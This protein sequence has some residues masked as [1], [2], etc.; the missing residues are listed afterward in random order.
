[1]SRAI[2]LAKRPCACC[3]EMYS[4]KR[5]GQA[6]CSIACGRKLAAKSKRKATRAKKRA[7]M[8]L[9]DARGVLGQSDA[10]VVLDP[11]EVLG[12]R[13]SQAHEVDPYVTPVAVDKS[14]GVVARS[15][16]KAKPLSDVERRALVLATPG[17]AEE[18]PLTGRAAAIRN[19]VAL[20]LGYIF[21][22]EPVTAG[23]GDPA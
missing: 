10:D 2:Y 13:G 21:E 6:A 12:L 3:G 20:E 18:M 4:P 9:R 16:T 11:R 22:S 5:Q 19:A 23:D 17:L 7:A 14:P 8:Q 1:M 15:V